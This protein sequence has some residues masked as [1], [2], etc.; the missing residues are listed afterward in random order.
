M[1]WS[2]KNDQERNNGERS[3][4]ISSKSRLENK[5]ADSQMIITIPHL[6]LSRLSVIWFLISQLFIALWQ[7]CAH[8]HYRLPA[9]PPITRG[10][11]KRR[12]TRDKRDIE[13]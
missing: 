3:L 2:I 5:P 13:K 4:M 10:L 6:S 8:S 11:R 1:Y 9:K 7:P 12:T